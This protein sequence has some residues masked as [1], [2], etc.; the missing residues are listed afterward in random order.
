[1]TRIL[2]VESGSRS[3]M[4]AAIPRLR[5]VFGE[6]AAFD[7]ITCYS[8]VPVTFDPAAPVWRTQDH[9]S[10][11]D[12]SRLVRE[13]KGSGVNVL[14]ILC[15]NEKIM[16]LWKW[17]LAWKLP[18]KVLIVNENADCF[19]LDTRHLGILRRF[20][21]TRMGLSGD[22]AGRTLARMAGFP[23]VLA[24]LLLYASVVHARRA[25]RK[26]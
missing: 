25:F 22:V 24:Y 1:M 7:L 16:T 19:W 6:Q 21:F 13:L 15:S 18:A 17:W 20:L 12:R 14:A 9:A 5:D 11:A 2:L 10:K 26:P 23:F 3:I 4:E 8:G